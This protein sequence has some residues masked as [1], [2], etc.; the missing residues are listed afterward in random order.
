[1]VPREFEQVVAIDRESLSKA[2]I[3][4]VFS[5]FSVST[6]LLIW[7]W[8]YAYVV[9][10]NWSSLAFN[11]ILQSETQPNAGI[12]KHP[13]LR[14]DSEIWVD[15]PK[16]I[17][18]KGRSGSSFRISRFRFDIFWYLNSFDL[19]WCHVSL[20][21]GLLWG[22]VFFQS[23]GSFRLW[24]PVCLKIKPYPT[25]DFWHR[26]EPQIQKIH[27]PNMTK[28]CDLRW[29]TGFLENSWS[30]RSCLAHGQSKIMYHDSI[31]AQETRRRW[32]NHKN[33]NYD[34]I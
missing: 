2:D 11:L 18:S 15:R 7:L 32:R 16:K 30:A 4:S 17:C 10:S 22:D 13:A 9:N 21:R 1:M 33:K 25:Y 34:Q 28:P 3:A 19:F 27:G 5:V 14:D 23:F 31:R 8:N 6:V 12:Y 29:P 26:H 24:M 20:L